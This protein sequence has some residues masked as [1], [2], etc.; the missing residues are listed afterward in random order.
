MGIMTDYYM[1]EIP[2]MLYDELVNTHAAVLR[3]TRAIGQ[4]ENEGN[5]DEVPSDECCNLLSEYLAQV[6][7]RLEQTRREA[8]ES[9]D[10]LGAYLVDQYVNDYEG[11]AISLDTLLVSLGE[12]ILDEE[13]AD[14]YLIMAAIDIAAAQRSLYRNVAGGDAFGRLSIEKVP[15]TINKEPRPIAF[16]EEQWDGVIGS[17][18]E[19][20]EEEL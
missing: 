8:W 16:F 7:N 15:F 11:L 9:Y 20:F 13:D 5:F 17:M 10:E 19:K 12:T 18:I 1:D 3:K 2:D 4:A 6:T 14:P